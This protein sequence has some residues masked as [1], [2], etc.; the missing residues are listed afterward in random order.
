MRA[1]VDAS[2]TACKQG[3]WLIALQ[4]ERISPML[5]TPDCICHTYKS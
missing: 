5:P 4:F 1:R 3:G 2:A